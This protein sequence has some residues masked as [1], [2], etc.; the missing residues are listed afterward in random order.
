MDLFAIDI[1]ALCHLIFKG[2]ASSTGRVIIVPILTI[3]LGNVVRYLGTNDQYASLTKDMF[4]WAP[5]FVVASFILLYQNMYSKIISGITPISQNDVMLF[6]MTL[7]LNIFLSIMIIVIMRKFGRRLKNRK[8]NESELT[9]GGGI[10]IPNILGS[11]ML[12]TNLLVM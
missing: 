2:I 5:D 9:I 1:A 3:F 12:L 8:R 10:I 11:I 4:H 7:A 6:M